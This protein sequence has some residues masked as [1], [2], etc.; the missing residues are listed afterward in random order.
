MLRCGDSLRRE[1][2][3]SGKGN[4]VETC[5]RCDNMW[6]KTLEICWKKD[7]NQGIDREPWLDVGAS[8]WRVNS[9]QYTTSESIQPHSGGPQVKTSDFFSYA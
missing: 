7:G 1:V 3:S 2:N 9:N 6:F 5:S 4:M 8:C